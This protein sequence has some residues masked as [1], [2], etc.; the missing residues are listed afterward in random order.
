MEKDYKKYVLIGSIPL[1]FITLLCLYLTTEGPP[2]SECSEGVW[3]NCNF[4]KP[5][6]E[7]SAAAKRFGGESGV[8]D[9]V[10][11]QAH[12]SN[13]TYLPFP[14]EQRENIYSYSQTDQV[15]PYLKKFDE[16]GLKVILSIQPNGA[17]IPELID[18]ILSKYGHHESIIGVN[19]D[20]EWKLT[21]EP[22]HVSDDERDL[23]LSRIQRYNPEFKLFLTYFKDYTYFPGDAQDIIILYDGDKAT[24]DL[25]M[26]E[27]E[28]LAS[29]Y[30]SVGIYT[31]Y[32]SSTP[33]TASYESIIA[34][35]PNT[36]YIL[37]IV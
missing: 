34:A 4:T 30:T 16:D 24:Q 2:Q 17:D 20:I 19:I 37:H 5:A 14:F 3:N 27:Y 6:E 9:L 13:L 31:G 32:S 8:V 7:W 29:H 26:R 25:L 35:A 18:I 21:G 22:Y 1:F 36:E 10:V 15:E 23:W 12:E 33:P 11:A 28:K